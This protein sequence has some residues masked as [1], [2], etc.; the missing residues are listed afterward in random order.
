MK[1]FKR[2]SLEVLRQRIDLPEVISQHIPLKRAGAAYKALCPFHD[3]KTPSFVI[4]KGDHHYHCFGCG[5]HGDAIQFLM[6]Y[7]RLSFVEAVE[8]LAERFQVPLEETESRQKKGPDRTVLKDAMEKATR[9]FHFLLLH[10]QEG[11]DALR[12]LYERGI[13]LKC[14]RDFQLGYAPRTKGIF[15]AAMK[16]QGVKEITLS[17]VGLISDSKRDFFIDR[18][19]IPIRDRIG[20]VIGFSARKF[21]PDTFGPKYINTSE[22]PLFK[23]S[24]VLFGLSYSRKRIAKEKRAIIVE[25]QIDAIRLIHN[26]F[27]ITVAGQGT[28]FG[29][30]QVQE[31]LNLGVRRIYLALDSDKAGRKAA[32]KIGNFF[33]K[34]GVEVSVVPMQEGMDPD[35]LLREKGPKIWEELLE[36]SIDYLSFLVDNSSKELDMNSP[37]EKNELVQTIANRIRGW[38]HPLMVHESLRRLA[39]LTHTPESMLVGQVSPSPIVIKQAASVSFQQIDPDRILEADL[40]RWLFFLGE[41]HPNI[42]KIAEKNLAEEHFTKPV[43]KRLFTK[44]ME[45]VREQKPRDLLSLTIDMQNAEEQL[46]LSE[47]LQKRINPEKG[48]E[49]FVETLQKLLDRRWMTQREEIKQKIYSA[50]TSEEEVME[51]ARRFDEIKNARPKVNSE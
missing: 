20:S 51:L 9:F 21:K 7:V 47:M 2:E 25:G 39:K 8:M 5:A 42:V 17:Q 13:D 14:I 37:A 34:D 28:A 48:E 40:L 10:S 12:Y 49:G 36:Q 18:I 33:Q 43:C 44:Y 46:F 29:E 6:S 32:I 45:T 11:A 23:K 15:Q 16:E 50:N 3:E 22:T 27:T 24:K 38:D 41:S 31:L 35:T 4:Q 30:G 26:G 19:Q 1:V